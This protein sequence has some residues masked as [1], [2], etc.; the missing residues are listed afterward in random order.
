MAFSGGVQ[1][2]VSKNACE[3]SRT[4]EFFKM[5]SGAEEEGSKLGRLGLKLKTRTSL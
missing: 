2:T 1:P 4:W 5:T 3:V